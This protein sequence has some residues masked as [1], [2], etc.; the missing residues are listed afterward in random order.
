MTKPILFLL[1]LTLTPIAFIHAN[2]YTQPN[3][4]YSTNSKDIIY[5]LEELEE[6][7]GSNV[8]KWVS[9]NKRFSYGLD[10]LGTGEHSATNCGPTTVAMVDKYLND[11]QS[12][13]IPKIRKEN[14]GDSSGWYN[15]NVIKELENMGARYKVENKVS[16][17][18]FRFNAN[19]AIS[20]EGLVIVCVNFNKLNKAH[21]PSRLGRQYDMLGYDGHFILIKGYVKGEDGKTYYETY[22][23]NRGYLDIPSLYS[24]QNIYYESENLYNALLFSD[25]IIINKY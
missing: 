12:M 3:I 6:I 2:Y 9:N 13:G 19:I 18:N 7:L 17:F 15:S 1:I 21:K 10:Q 8:V 4:L 24:N 11:T 23:P 25:Y 14:Y 16:A 20:E 5:T 22:D